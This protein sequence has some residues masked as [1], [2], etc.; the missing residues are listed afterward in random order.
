[1]KKTDL[2]RTPL[3]LTRRNT[4]EE[5]TQRSTRS[6]KKPRRGLKQA[7]LKSITKDL[8]NVKVTMMVSG[9]GHFDRNYD[10]THYH[11]M[12]AKNKQH[13]QVVVNSAMSW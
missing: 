10:I 6:S 8:Y 7:W 11:E 2:V 13:W 9:G 4:S 12:L 3:T 5:S 1:M